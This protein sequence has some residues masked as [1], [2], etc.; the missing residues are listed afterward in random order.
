L[1]FLR[2]A[3]LAA[4]LLLG[5]DGDARARAEADHVVSAVRALRD[6]NDDDKPARLAALRA[7]ACQDP[8][9]T[10]LKDECVAAY[11]LYLAGRDATRAVKK[12]LDSDG[13]DVT[14]A[15]LLLERA[16]KDVQAGRR[17]AEAC[18]LLEGQVSVRFKLK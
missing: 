15:R 6:A 13:G 12:S 1:A 5:C 18:N 9:V 7:T 8:K 16:E 2:G 11:E 17:R 4:F 10:E 3:V 14:G